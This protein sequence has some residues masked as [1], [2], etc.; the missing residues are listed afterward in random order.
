[1]NS[2]LFLFL[3][4]IFI[5]KQQRISH[6]FDHASCCAIPL[7]YRLNYGL[8]FCIV[9]RKDR[10]LRKNLLIASS[11]IVQ[12]SID[13]EYFRDSDRIVIQYIE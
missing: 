5:E 1:M 8:E 4:I 3:M 9:L 7:N 13:F 11:S 12:G 2:Q 10:R 6:S